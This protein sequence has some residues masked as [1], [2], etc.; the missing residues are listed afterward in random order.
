MRSVLIAVVF[1]SGCATV[2]IAGAGGEKT[3]APIEVSG[4]VTQACAVNAGQ[5]NVTVT[6]RAAGE[7][8]P[9]ATA[10]TDGTGAFSFKVQPPSAHAKLLVEALGRK[11]LATQQFSEG[12]PLIAELRLP[13]PS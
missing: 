6:L 3:A 10:V 8:E 4:H 2:P 11:A 9:L 1:L 12:G 5:A 7:L 13:C